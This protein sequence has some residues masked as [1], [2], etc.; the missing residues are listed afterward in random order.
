[1]STM[2]AFDIPVA[3]TDTETTGKDPYTDRIVEIAVVRIE[4]DGMRISLKSLV[5]PGVP[6]PAEA[7][8]V[9]GIRDEDVKG[10]P[11][12]AELC[13]TDNLGVLLKG[14]AIGGHNARGYDV[15]LMETEFR[16]H[17]GRTP[18]GDTSPQVVDTLDVFRKLLP[19]TL[20]GAVRFF[21]GREHAGA[22]AAL[23]DV[24]ATIEVL[25]AMLARHPELPRAA[26]ELARWGLPEE[27][28]NWVDPT[29]KLIRTDA[30]IAINFGKHAGRLVDAMAREE[31]GYLAWMLAKSFHPSVH[32]VL[33]AALEK[34][35]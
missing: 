22:H 28:K 1:M 5:N 4:P 25:E 7:T 33:R 26:G 18:W 27:A 15:P 6:I 20:E 9:H 31:R 12:F 35:P 21:L 8:A 34:K 32:Q 10:A 13:R 3:F 14:C 23:A 2:L 19:H 17:F 24:L 30:G 29:G 11:T 16:R